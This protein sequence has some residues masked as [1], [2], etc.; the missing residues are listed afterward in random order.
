MEII[1]KGDVN[2]LK[3]MMKYKQNMIRQVIRNLK[4]SIK[5]Q[6]KAG[7]MPYKTGKQVWEQETLLKHYQITHAFPV[8][9][10]GIV[11]NLN[12]LK[13]FISKLKGFE[14]TVRHDDST[15][16]LTYCKGETEG[17][18]K[19]HNLIHYYRD[20]KNIPKVELVL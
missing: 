2:E 7:R 14:I 17:I 3:R 19:L 15:V 9:Y 1:I 10:E 11:I 6:E 5:A 8:D 20:F 13:R 16:Y 18:L 4:D 12:L